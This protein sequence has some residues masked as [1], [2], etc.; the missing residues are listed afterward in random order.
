MCCSCILLSV[1]SIIFDFRGLFFDHCGA[2]IIT[3]YPQGD[4]WVF[5][6]FCKYMIF[7]ASIDSPTSGK[8]YICVDSMVLPFVCLSDIVCLNLSGAI[9]VDYLFAKFMFA[10]GSYISRLALKR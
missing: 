8:V 3:Q 4:E 10:P 2:A 5:L 7:L 6:H 1:L 9:L